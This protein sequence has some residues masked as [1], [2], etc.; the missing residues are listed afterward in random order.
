MLK[1][2]Y[3]PDLVWLNPNWRGNN[4]GEQPNWCNSDFVTLCYEE[5][6][7]IYPEHNDEYLQE[8]IDNLKQKGIDIS[9]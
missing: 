1:R 9:V 2:G 8:C 4:L 5:N 3:S 7:Y 6:G